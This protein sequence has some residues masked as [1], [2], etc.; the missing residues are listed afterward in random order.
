M[1]QRCNVYD[2][3]F[4]GLFGTTMTDVLFFSN[5]GGVGS[6]VC[7]TIKEAFCIYTIIGFSGNNGSRMR[8]FSFVQGENLDS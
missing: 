3:L 8:F 4:V 7:V 5:M 1:M 2:V 6:G